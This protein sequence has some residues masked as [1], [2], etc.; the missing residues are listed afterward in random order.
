[1]VDCQPLLLEG[2]LVHKLMSIC[3]ARCKFA[4]S[5][6]RLVETPWQLAWLSA[7]SSSKRWLYRYGS[8]S[9]VRLAAAMLPSLLSA[10]IHHQRPAKSRACKLATS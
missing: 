10:R 4:P 6:P 7:L 3:K 2:K 1:M 9:L 5:A 8:L